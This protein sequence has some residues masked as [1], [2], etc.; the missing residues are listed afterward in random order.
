MIN[1]GDDVCDVHYDAFMREGYC[2]FVQQL[3]TL[4]SIYRFCYF[5]FYVVCAKCFVN[6][7]DMSINCIFVYKQEYYLL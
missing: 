2:H 3:I 6:F 5:I 7:D 1:G 4:N